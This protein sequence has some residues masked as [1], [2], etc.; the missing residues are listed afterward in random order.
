MTHSTSDR[1]DSL[2]ST[3]FGRTA[4]GIL[5]VVFFLVPFAMRGARVSVQNMRNDVKDWLPAEFQ[6]TTDINW[7]WRHFLGERFVLASWDNCTADDES[8]KLMMAKLLPEVPPSL[9]GVDLEAMAEEAA[10]KVAAASGETAGSA[11]AGEAA[12][13]DD[14][15]ALKLE[16]GMH[17]VHLERPYPFIGDRLGLFFTGQDHYNWGGRKEKWVQG[18]KGLW[19]FLTPE[20]EL[21]EWDGAKAPIAAFAGKAWRGISGTRLEA[22][23]VATFTPEDAAWYYER[24]RRLD[25]QLFRSV[26]TGP[27]VLEGLTAEGGVLE[28]NEQEAQRRLQGSL[29]GKDGKTTALVLNFTE[30]GRSDL[31]RVMGRGMLGRPRGRLYDLAEECGVSMSQLHLGGPTVDNVAIDEEGTITLVRL[32]SLCVILGIGLSYACFRSISATLMVI[33]VGG[34]SAVASV[35]LVGWSGATLD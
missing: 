6:E 8:Y 12:K 34:V 3:F 1:P 24:P 32:V 28:G 26:T 23:R 9:A 21:Y 31:H 19:Y 17:N 13:P 35:E 10:A 27:T 30:A 16:R 5:M 4:L 15:T 14:P 2:R 18:L 25:A 7:F 11:A 33:F 22:K 29:F 20:G